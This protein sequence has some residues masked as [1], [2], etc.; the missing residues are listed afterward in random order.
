MTDPRGV[1]LAP[2]EPA[3][4][5]AG[6]LESL[7]EPKVVPWRVPA[8]VAA[9]VAALLVIGWITTPKFVTVNNALIIVR[10]ASII[11]IVALGMTFVTISG[12]Y[13]SLSVG[14][15][16]SFSA[17]VFSFAISQ[18]WGVAAA[19]GVTLAF[20]FTVGVLQ[21]LVVAAGANPIITTLAAGATLFGLAAVVTDNKTVR[22]GSDAAS[23][24]GRGRPFGIP[25]QTYAFV[26]LTVIAAVA[27]AKTP[28]GRKVTLA[29]ANAAAAAA[30]GIRRG[31]V[32]VV[33]FA[34]A[35][36]GAGLAGMFTAAQVGQGITQQVPELNINAIAAVLVGGAAIS[37]GEG[38]MFRTALGAVFIAGLD[39]LMVLRGYSYGFRV[40]LVGLAVLVG[41]SVFNA[42]RR[43]A[44]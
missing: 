37:G 28:F 4:P 21:G 13:F 12:N 7:L 9:A 26:V 35:S 33:V 34:L 31:T 25:N 42:M 32:A 43:R 16:A 15:T 2:D 24:L 10:S 44:T 20:A 3:P 11:G 1:D 8:A 36:L 39:N 6:D 38:S 23:W 19:V 40:L 14:E 41:V 29:G 27:L 5:V 22:V 17:I 30:V 18:D